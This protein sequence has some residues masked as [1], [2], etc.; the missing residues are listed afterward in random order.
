MNNTT[1][2][3]LH[4]AIIMPKIFLI[5]NGFISGFLRISVENCKLAVQFLN[6]LVQNVFYI[7][8]IK[9]DSHGYLVFGFFKLHLNAKDGWRGFLNAPYALI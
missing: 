7:Q 8:V 5:E 4:R 1:V 9:M 6:R 2:H 3:T